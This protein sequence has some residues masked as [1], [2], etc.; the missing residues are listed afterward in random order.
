MPIVVVVMFCETQHSHFIV[1][2]RSNLIVR[3]HYYNYAPAISLLKSGIIGTFIIV[4]EIEQ[5][6]TLLLR[7]NYRTIYSDL[8][9]CK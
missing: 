4:F 6:K 2:I 8:W 1:I 3:L 9:Q 5:K 7:Y